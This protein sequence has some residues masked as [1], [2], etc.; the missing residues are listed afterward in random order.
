M[1]KLTDAIIGMV[2]SMSDRKA[3]EYPI[4]VF[5]KGQEISLD[6]QWIEN[7]EIH[8]SIEDPI[9]FAKSGARGFVVTE[10]PKRMAI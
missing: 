9:Y 7:G 8:V 6:D 4:R 5:L 1:E 10:T 3:K 2:E